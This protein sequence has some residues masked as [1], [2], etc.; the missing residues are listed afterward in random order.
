MNRW[1]RTINGVFSIARDATLNILTS[2]AYDLFYVVENADWSIRWD[3]KYITENLN[4]QKLLRSKVIV[5]DIGIR[6]KIIHYGSENTLIGKSGI[7]RLDATNK[8]VVTWF[9]VSPGDE[10]T[11]YVPALNKIAAKVHTS[12][13]ITKRELISWGLKEDKIAVI[14]LGVDLGLFRP[15]T[16]NEKVALRKKFNI[17][18]GKIVI[19]SFQK[20]GNGWGEGLEPKMI[21]GPD[22]FCDVVAGLNKKFD[23]HVLLTGP[24]RGYVKRRLTEQG[25]SFTHQYLDRYE[26]IAEYYRA[27]DLYIVASRAEGG[28]K[29]ILESMASGIPV[30]SSEV[31]MAPDAIRDGWNGLLAP[32]DSTVDLLGKSSHIIEEGELRS[33]IVEN[34]LVEVKKYDWSVIARAYMEQIYLSMGK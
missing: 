4:Q 2:R 31:G 5:D 16:G 24:A 9:H 34:A 30:V 7:K 20:D 17:P 19:G 26:K 23:I 33:K 21:K 29:S 32:V 13:Q 1:L 25:I 3:G 11:K 10:R 6:N 22:V 14:P 27:L 12:C 28:P 18:D 15:P 8:A